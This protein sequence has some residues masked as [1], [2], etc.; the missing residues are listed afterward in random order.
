[1]APNERLFYS[2]LQKNGEYAGAAI[3]SVEIDQDAALAYVV[4]ELASGNFMHWSSTTISNTVPA[5]GYTLFGLTVSANNSQNTAMVIERFSYAISLFH[6]R[7]R[8]AR[9]A[10][11]A[12][13][14]V[15]QRSALCN[16]D[17]RGIIARMIFDMRSTWTTPPE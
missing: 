14:C 15:A 1:L 5:Y 12:W 3:Q 9:E 8:Q 11:C 10:A 16:K 17:V 2:C 4:G 7:T 6:I 13:T